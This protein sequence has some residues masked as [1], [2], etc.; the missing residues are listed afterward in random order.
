MYSLWLFGRHVQ[1]TFIGRWSLDLYR[2]VV[3]CSSDLYRRWSH[4]T[5]LLIIPISL[6]SP[7]P[8]DEFGEEIYD[9]PE[10]M[11]GDGQGDVPPPPPPDDPPEWDEDEENFYDESRKTHMYMYM[12][13]YA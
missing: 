2:E 12:Y 5:M 7:P 8:E 10:D 1:V 11:R 3:T 6:F 4:A 13:R 9:I